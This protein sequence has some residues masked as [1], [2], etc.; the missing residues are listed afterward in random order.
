[1]A[2]RQIVWTSTAENSLKDI[3]Q[4]YFDVTNSNIYGNTLIENINKS[5]LNIKTFN[6]I[7]RATEFPNTRVLF[8]NHFEIFYQI[9]ADTIYIKLIWDSR[10]NP[11]DLKKLL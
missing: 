7:G 3:T 6:L 9:S 10:R 5:I 2:Q 1:M 4:F 8:L 11:D